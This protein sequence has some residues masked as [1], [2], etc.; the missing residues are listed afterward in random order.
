MRA[1]AHWPAGVPVGVIA[2]QRP[3]RARHSPPTCR[4]WRWSRCTSRSG[5]T[6]APT[7]R[8][9]CCARAIGFRARSAHRRRAGGHAAAAASHRLRCRG[10][11]RRPV[12][13]SGGTRARLLPRPLPGRRGATTGRC[14]PP[15][16]PPALAKAA[17]LSSSDGGA[18]YERDRPLRPRQ[19]ASTSASRIPWPML[20]EPRQRT[21]AASCRRPAWAPRTWS[22]PT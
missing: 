16:G 21:P 1:R 12:G 6:A 8:H 20:Q 18:R 4:V 15:A 13:G 7:A 9:A 3:G 11:A 22:S 5:P 19:P 2:R 17:S 10:A 14:S